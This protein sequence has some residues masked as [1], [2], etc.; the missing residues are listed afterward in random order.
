MQE[1]PLTRGLVALVDDEDYAEVSKYKWFANNNGYAARNVKDQ[2][3][4]KRTTLVMHRILMGLEQGDTRQVDHVDGNRVN[5]CRSNMRIVMP[6][7][8]AKNRK[9]N[10][11]NTSGYKGVVWR[12]SS[13]KWVAQIGVNG[14]KVGLGYFDDPQKAYEAYCAASIRL[15]GEFGKA[16]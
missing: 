10:H 16:A 12:K 2:S 8:N 4:G 9:G 14:K 1:I 11:N 13:R 5:N 6:A 7:E 15:H 3:T